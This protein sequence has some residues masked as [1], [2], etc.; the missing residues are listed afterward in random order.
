MAR[1]G[2]LARIRASICVL[3]LLAACAACTSQLTKPP[4]QYE[5]GVELPAGAGREILATSCLS[6][7]DLGG[8]ELFKGFYARDSWR[9]LVLTM[10]A[11]GAVI[12][13]G[14]IEVLADYLEMYFG[15]N[16]RR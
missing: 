6:C 14:E 4:A 15:P 10:Q 3:G 9:A 12:E 11:N 5:A 16:P 8:L 7:H 2:W 1:S 13:P